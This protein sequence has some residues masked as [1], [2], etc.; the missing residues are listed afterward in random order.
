MQFKLRIDLGNVGM[1]HP[2]H[3]ASALREVARV[4]DERPGASASWADLD[5]SRVRDVNGNAVGTWSIDK[6]TRETLQE[7]YTLDELESRSTLHEGQSADLKIDTGE[8]RVWLERV[9]L[10]DGAPYDNGVTVEALVAGHWV[11]TAEYEA[12]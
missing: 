1:Q 3:V 6:T 8:Q 10:L 2:G 9:G 7:R 11:T 12:A 4:L 5:G